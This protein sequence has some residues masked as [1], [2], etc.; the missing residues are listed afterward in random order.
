MHT[1]TVL[2]MPVPVGLAVSSIP[3]TTGAG[4][5]AFVMIVVLVGSGHHHR[6]AMVTVA[7]AAVVLAG[8]TGLGDAVAQ[9]LGSQ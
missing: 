2:G 8:V 7:V 1:Y 5:L 9:A 4:I 6:G 3:L